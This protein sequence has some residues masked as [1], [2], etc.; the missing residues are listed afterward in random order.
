L[1]QQTKERQANDIDLY[2]N[3]ALSVSP[4]APA[5][6]ALEEHRDDGMEVSRRVG[7]GRNQRPWNARRAK[8]DADDSNRLR[9][10]W[11]PGRKNG[12]V[13][14]IASGRRRLWTS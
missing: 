5:R 8:G 4:L 6:F 2:Q 1:T 10:R 7:D 11:R 12:L 9:I 14:N 13:S 3:S